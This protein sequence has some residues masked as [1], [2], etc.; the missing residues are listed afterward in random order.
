VHVDLEAGK[1]LLNC[2]DR[3]TP[4][5]TGTDTN[6]TTGSTHVERRLIKPTFSDPDLVKAEAEERDRAYSLSLLRR[7]GV[8]SS[9]AVA[10]TVRELEA[11]KGSRERKRPGRP[12][13]GSILE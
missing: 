5:R 6:K 7:F 1:K 11:G 13:M 10:D 2:T 12:E 4:I 9:E 3:R 8:P